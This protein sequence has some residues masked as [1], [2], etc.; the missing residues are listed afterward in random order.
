MMTFVSVLEGRAVG[1]EFRHR[2]MRVTHLGL[3]STLSVLA[4][5]W[6]KALRVICGFVPQYV[7]QTRDACPGWQKRPGQCQTHRG[8]EKEV[9]ERPLSD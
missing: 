7:P 9:G 1:A 6:R 4:W 3:K 5:L 2:L 8:E